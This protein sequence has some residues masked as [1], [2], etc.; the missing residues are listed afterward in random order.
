MALRGCGAS[1]NISAAAAGMDKIWRQLAGVASHQICNINE[2]GPFFVVYPPSPTFHP[3]TDRTPGAQKPRNSR[4]RD[5]DAVL[6]FDRDAQVAD[7]YVWHGHRHRYQRGGCRPRR[8]RRRRLAAPL[9]V[10]DVAGAAA[11]G[12]HCRASALSASDVGSIAAGGRRGS[13]AVPLC[14]VLPGGGGGG[15]QCV[16][17]YRPGGK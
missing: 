15:K 17:G 3:M 4:F 10:G 1:A 5:L 12:R 11:A 8:P 9:S 13:P 6:K 16:H 14:R 7:N 2:T